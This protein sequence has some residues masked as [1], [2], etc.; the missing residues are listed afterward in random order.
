[1]LNHVLKVSILSVPGGLAFAILS[2]WIVLNFWKKGKCK[3]LNLKNNSK[4]YLIQLIVIMSFSI[5]LNRV[6]HDEMET[7]IVFAFWIFVCGVVLALLIAAIC[8]TIFLKRGES[9]GSYFSSAFLDSHI[10][11]LACSLISL[12]FMD[13]ECR[14]CGPEAIILVVYMFIGIFV[15]FTLGSITGYAVC[16]HYHEKHFGFKQYQSKQ[17]IP[18]ETEIL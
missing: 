14:G 6:K 1:M 18:F 8:T 17:Q 2:Y 12:S 7:I 10:T 9:S 15:S 5:I 4:K 16:H 13:L 11:G 3:P